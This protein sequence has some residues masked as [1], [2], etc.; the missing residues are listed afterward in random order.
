MY[1]PPYAG[2]QPD[3]PY[4]EAMDTVYAPTGVI[5]AGSVMQTL[6]PGLAAE[7]PPVPYTPYAYA[8]IPVPP[9]TPA[10]TPQDSPYEEET[11]NNF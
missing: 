11:S 7:Q 6:A 2:Y 8:F 3:V 10:R 9:V 1:A 4:Y 5:P